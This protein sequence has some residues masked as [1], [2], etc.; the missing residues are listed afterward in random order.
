MTLELRDPFAR[1][2]RVRMIEHA[3]NATCAWCGNKRHRA[4]KPLPSLFRFE[5]HSDGGRTTRIKGLFCSTSCL[6][7]YYR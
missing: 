2:T 6:E 4:G 1:E 7:T 5:I 3:P